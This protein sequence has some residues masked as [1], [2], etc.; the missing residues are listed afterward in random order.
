MST[1]EKKR[2][3]HIYR[4]HH[5]SDPNSFYIGS[6][7]EPL[8][9]RL[10]KHKTDAKR[11]PQKKRKFY[12]YLRQHNYNDFRIQAIASVEYET[13]QDLRIAEDE[14]IRRL[15]PALNV[16]KAVRNHEDI[17]ESNVKY[18]KSHYADV[19]RR[20]KAWNA[21]NNQKHQCRTCNF[22]TAFPAALTRHN[23]TKRHLA[24]VQS[25]ELELT[26]QTDPWVNY[27]SLFE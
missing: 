10:Q 25:A 11:N 16:N 4:I 2:T 24:K 23:K 7:K 8:I 19:N 1:E 13:K 20:N 22:N 15:K 9:R 5:V 14:A 17:K 21:A 12:E 6:T 3:G 18:Y 26:Q 27:D